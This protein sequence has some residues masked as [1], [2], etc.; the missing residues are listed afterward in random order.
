M[1]YIWSFRVGYT[2][3]STDHLSRYKKVDYFVKSS[4]IRI[5]IYRAIGKS[6]KNVQEVIDLEWR[7]V[8]YTKRI[9]GV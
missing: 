9:L 2:V 5:K 1:P 3:A 4:N 6:S 7:E 8:I